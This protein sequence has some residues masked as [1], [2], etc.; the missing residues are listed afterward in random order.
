MGPTLQPSTKVTLFFD[1]D[2]A[3]LRVMVNER[4][5]FHFTTG[6]SATAFDRFAFN[7][8]EDLVDG[9]ATLNGNVF[10]VHASGG[11]GIVVNDSGQIIFNSEVIVHGPHDAF[12]EDPAIAL[13]AALAS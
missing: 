8:V 2:R 11:G 1:K 12:D 9:T 5:M 6:D 13:C 3:P 10:N 7:V 4:G